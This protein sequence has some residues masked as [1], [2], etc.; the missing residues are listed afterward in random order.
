MEKSQNNQLLTTFVLSLILGAYI[1]YFFPLGLYLG[2]IDE[3]VYPVYSYFR[4]L[5]LFLLVASIFL[6]L[7]ALVLKGDAGRRY[8]VFV[9]TL[10]L[11]VWFQGNVLVWE[12]GLLDGKDINWNI[13]VW[14]GWIDA[15]I[16][17][18]AIAISIIF[19]RRAGKTL[20]QL[21]I[22]LFFLQVFTNAYAYFASAG[23]ISE[24]SASIASAGQISGKPDS[25]NGSKD[26]EQMR[27]F[28]PDKN[29]LHIILD[30]FQADIFNEI[31]NHGRDKDYFSTLDG[32]VFFK[33]HMGAFPTTYYSVPALLGGEVYKN[34][35]PKKEFVSQ[36]MSEKSVLN[37]A[38]DKGYEVD[39]ASDPKLTGIYTEGS[40]TNAYN[41]PMNYLATGRESYVDE[42]FKLIDLS[43]FRLAPHFIK[44]QI[45][46]DQR[47]FFQ[48]LLYTDQQP[49]FNYFSHNAFLTD[50]VLNLNLNRAAPV[51]KYFHLMSTHWPFVVD[52]SDGNCH[53]AGGPLPI[54]RDT[55][56]W[57]MRCTLDLVISLLDKMRQAG[58][59]DTSLIIIMGDHGAQITPLRYESTA[60]VNEDTYQFDLDGW[61]MAQNTP[62]ML[63]KLPNKNG[64]L[65]VSD[66]PTSMLDT[67]ETINTIL[68][69]GRDYP[70]ESMFSLDPGR[71]RTRRHY[72]YYW[73]REDY[74]TEYSESIQ[75]FIVNGSIYDRQAW[76]LGAEYNPP[77]D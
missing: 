35:I 24:K 29:V 16:W 42:A 71:E 12:Y 17:A 75:E 67:A 66:A 25:N 41:I 73:S 60:A 52:G 36:V 74:V 56:T 2:N 7:P 44:K 40:Y 9:G 49:M 70:G 39:I 14:R 54:K 48:S 33:E 34:H 51:Y 64:M 53:Y 23:R 63:I 47:W 13:G 28:S 6:L 61:I 11:L 65:E 57:Q 50:L 5:T 62:L 15:G 10:G 30:S 26:I 55:A 4:L 27:A 37:A 46:N 32:F 22:V 43:L 21:A 19:Y 20:I 77:P 59:Y 18:A 31:I 72:F 3:F 45:Y 8:Q 58:I 68:D 1:F 38:Y 76:Q 69:L